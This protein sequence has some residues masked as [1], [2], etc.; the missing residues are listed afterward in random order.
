[1]RS[2]VLRVACVSV[3]CGLLAMSAFGQSSGNLR[4][5][6]MDL[7]R[8][9]SEDVTALL[10]DDLDNIYYATRGGLT[11]EDR[12]GNRR[13]YTRS[14]TQGAM[15]SDSLLCMSVDRFRDVWI[16]T[17]G[18]GLL[19]Y[20][21]GGWR[22]HDHES[23]RGGIPDDAILSITIHRDER[24]IGT[25]NGFAVMR[26]ASWQTWT[27]E[28]IAGRLPHPAVAA[29]AVDSS[30]DKWLGT[31]GGLVRLRGTAVWTRFTM[32]NTDGGMPHS[33]VTALAVDAD[34]ALWVG[35]QAGLARR[36]RNG[37]WTRFDAN[38]EGPGSERITSVRPGREEGEIW[39]SFRGGAARLHDGHWQRFTRDN[40]PGLLTLFVNDVLPGPDGQ[41]H[42][43]THKGV[44]A[45]LP[46]VR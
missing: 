14:G 43:A 46:S 20:S 30:G 1:M 44:I 18:G 42:I 39:V 41:V 8:L 4:W 24:W 11:V 34:N 13:V 35:T 32:E 2:G 21:G 3:L 12:A 36:A 33:G 17:D 6:L 45:R 37:V 10:R 28:R 9:P 22:H 38:P 29:I 23:T 40:V 16:G 25:R 7:G 5:S 27:G 19:V 31:Q 26:G 15:V